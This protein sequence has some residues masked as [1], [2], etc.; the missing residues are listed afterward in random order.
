MITQLISSTHINVSANIGGL[1][2]E[3]QKKAAE[4]LFEY[5]TFNLMNSFTET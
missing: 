1:L 2:Q 5:Y 3:L 4:T